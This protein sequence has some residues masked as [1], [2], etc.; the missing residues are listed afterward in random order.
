[1]T[2]H[3]MNK[4]GVPLES[5]L[6]MMETCKGVGIS[7]VA[8]AHSRIVSGRKSGSGEERQMVAGDE[9]KRDLIA[10]VVSKGHGKGRLSEEEVVIG[11]VE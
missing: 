7:L 9:R 5:T 8:S 4:H 10:A 2:K 11:A 6:K 1:M 3:N